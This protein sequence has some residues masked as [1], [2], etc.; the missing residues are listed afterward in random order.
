MAGL[1]VWA[2]S[3]YVRVARTLRTV[4]ARCCLVFLPRDRGL[5]DTGVPSHTELASCRSALL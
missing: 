5:W 1:W 2:L 3:P 4:C